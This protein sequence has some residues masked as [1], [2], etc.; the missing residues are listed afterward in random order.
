MSIEMP[1]SSAAPESTPQ[2]SKSKSSKKEKSS[3]NGEKKRKR[4]NGDLDDTPKSKSKKQKADESDLN[5]SQSSA[6]KPPR[7]DDEE[8]KSKKKKH[9]AAKP[10]PESED[11]EMEDAQTPTPKSKKSHHKLNPSYRI[12]EIPDEVSPFHLQTSSLYLGLAPISQKA[13]IEGLC[14]EHISPLLLTYYPP[15]EGVILSF[16]NPRISEQPFENDGPQTLLRNIDEYAVSWAWL[17]A[18]F[19]LFKPESGAWLEGYV[20]LQNEGHLGVVCW[21]LFNASISRNRLPSEWKWIGV[22]D[23]EAVE[24]ER[25]GETYATD[26]IGYWMDG[27]GKKVDGM[28]KFKVSEIENSHDRERGFLNIK[29]TML[30]E[31]AEKDM[32]YAEALKAPATDKSGKRIGLGGPTAPGATSLGVPKEDRDDLGDFKPR[33]HRRK[34]KS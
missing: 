27:N 6:S 13:P 28:I 31:E 15:F 25:E 8:T 34:Y 2:K 9:K 22:E 20:N 3:S 26:G 19:L 10:A 5:A 1:S 21:N 33:Q 17:T 18:E 7:G 30:S 4:D 23:E 24:G 32:L 11:V 14:A 12:A 29:G 16:S